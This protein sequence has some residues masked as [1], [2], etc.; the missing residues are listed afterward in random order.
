[1][2][3]TAIEATVEA[4]QVKLPPHLRLPDHTKVYILVPEAPA[5]A[6]QIATPRLLHPQE[7]ADFRKTVAEEA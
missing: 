1:V 2:A 4:G 6:P 3:T 5:P 7:A